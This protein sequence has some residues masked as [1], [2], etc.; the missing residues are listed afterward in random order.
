MRFYV[1]QKNVPV[2]FQSRYDHMA[3]IDTNLISSIFHQYPGQIVHDRQ[4]VSLSPA[5]ADIFQ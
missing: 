1:G 2:F 3:Q 5:V 4:V